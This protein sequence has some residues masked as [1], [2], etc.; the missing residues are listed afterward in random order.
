[1]EVLLMQ[2]ARQRR[3]QDQRQQPPPPQ[4]GPQRQYKRQE[5]LFRIRT[6]LHRLREQDIIRSYRLNWQAILQL[7]HHIEP[8]LTA[9]L[10]TPHN[11]PPVNKLLAVLH[12]LASGSF[13]T[14]G[15]L[16]AAVS[17]PSFLA[18]M[19]K[20]L[21]AIIFLTS[22]H[23]SFPNTQQ[24]Q[25]KIKQEFYQI[26][27]FSHLLGAIDCTHI[28]I[29][30]PAATEH[31]FRNRKHTHSINVQARVSNMLNCSMTH[32]YDISNYKV[33]K[34]PIHEAQDVKYQKDRN[35]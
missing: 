24:K 18:F 26:H 35:V 10:R 4:R 15:C 9:S 12:M 20:V 19:P 6:T 2:L 3:A 34:G 13:Q 21:D 17:Q 28:R 27:G 14:T 16:V 5:R 11:I 1:M 30:P 8:H 32:N 29:V 25:Q 23:I 22:H 7:L 31:L 33:N